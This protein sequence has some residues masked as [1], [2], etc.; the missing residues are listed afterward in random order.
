VDQ[1]KRLD[2]FEALL[3]FSPVDILSE[4]VV[5]QFLV[6]INDYTCNWILESILRAKWIIVKYKSFK[7]FTCCEQRSSDEDDDDDQYEDY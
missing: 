1:E 6:R 7:E 2:H 3:V 4:H 5:D